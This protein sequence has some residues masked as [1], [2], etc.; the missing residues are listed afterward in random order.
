MQVTL[1][2]KSRRRKQR[3]GHL[4]AIATAHEF[5]HLKRC[6]GS[7]SHIRQEG[8]VSTTQRTQLPSIRQTNLGVR[9][10]DRRA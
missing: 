1:L 4:R 10:R 7:A 3:C 6:R 5:A 2:P 8:P 9:H